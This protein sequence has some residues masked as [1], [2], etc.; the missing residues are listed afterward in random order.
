[1]H[2]VDDEGQPS[3]VLLPIEATYC[4]V[5][6]CL[7]PLPASALNNIVLN[8]RWHKGSSDAP[9]HSV[10]RGWGLHVGV[11]LT[12]WCTV[13][14]GT[15]VAHDTRHGRVGQGTHRLALR[16]D[17]LRNLGVPSVDLRVA[18]ILCCGQRLN[19]LKRHACGQGDLLIAS[20]EG[21]LEG[22]GLSTSALVVPL[23][24]RLVPCA[25]SINP[26]LS[27]LEHLLI[28]TL[29]LSCQPHT[30]KVKAGAQVL[31]KLL[32]SSEDGLH[33][34]LKAGEV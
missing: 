32:A 26:A 17:D 20:T 16:L 10:V 18:G 12:V 28:S 4:E 3:E 11:H 29:L 24:N 31:D 25:I 30:V 21:T 27:Q 14:A 1:M 9:L 15:D 2:L 5:H 22:V 19:I 23:L 6:S 7:S 33:I 13:V 8:L 34:H